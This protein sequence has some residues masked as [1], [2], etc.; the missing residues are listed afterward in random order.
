ME[1]G[2]GRKHGQFDNISKKPETD[3]SDGKLFGVQDQ[4][5]LVRCFGL[6]AYKSVSTYF[7]S[8]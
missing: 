5:L 3:N 4:I 2:S 8:T 7:M 6:V 1:E